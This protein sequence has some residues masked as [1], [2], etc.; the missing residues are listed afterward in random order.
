[1]PEIALRRNETVVAEWRPSLRI[2]LRKMVFVAFVTAVL[3]GGVG[4]QYGLLFWLAGLPLAMAV[5]MLIFDDYTEWVRRRGDIWRLTN[6]RLM[7]FGTS[8]SE[9]PAS[10]DLTDIRDVQH[11]M[12]WA[13]K[14][15]MSNGQTTTMSFLPDLESVRAKLLDMRDKAGGA[16][17]A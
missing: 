4:Y 13:I 16:A 6:Q 9:G 12:W 7:L 5:Y 15:K 8:E 2:F 10:V 14:V 1:M 3:L 17:H 11:W